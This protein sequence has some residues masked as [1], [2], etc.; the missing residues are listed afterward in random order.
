[1]SLW[2]MVSLAVL[3]LVGAAAALELADFGQ[4]EAFHGMEI[5][6]TPKHPH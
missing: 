2:N 4:V 5:L 6:I 1:M 3:V